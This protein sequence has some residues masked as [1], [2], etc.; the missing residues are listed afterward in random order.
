MK[1]NAGKE[2]LCRLFGLTRQAW[3]EHQWREETE[4]IDEGRVLEIV[5]AKRHAHQGLKKSSGKLMYQI[6]KPELQ[7]N[8]VKMGRDK[9]L[10]VFR[11]YGW[12]KKRRRI[13]V[14]TTFSDVNLPLFPNLT[15]NI[16]L[17]GPEQLWVA[18]IT[19]VRVGEH[20]NYLSIVTDAYS[21]RIMGY[22][23]S[24]TLETSG[25]LKA[26]EMALT[27]RLYPEQELVHHSDRGFQ[28]RSQDY[29]KRLR[30]NAIQSSMTQSGDPRENA[31]AER[32]NGVLKVDMG[33]ADVTYDSHIDTLP[34]VDAI[35]RTYNEVRPH[36]SIDNLTPMQA[37]QKTGKIK[38]RWKKLEGINEVILA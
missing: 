19:Y 30:A 5:N 4:L 17:S 6:I 34:I 18:D 16:K 33:L 20:F 3:Y 25:C 36:S 32:I 14:R 29:I 24:E 15:E 10:E 2:R 26:L 11:K 23:L 22:C 9:V 38:N 1:V 8:G 7:F 27:N 28:Y 21:R 35:I 13:R 37:H 31:I 12:M